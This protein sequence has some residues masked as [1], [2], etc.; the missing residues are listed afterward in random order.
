MVVND[1]QS[2]VALVQILY[3][4]RKRRNPKWPAH[5]KHT[6]GT[7]ERVIATIANAY[8]YRARIQV[9]DFG[10]VTDVK[11]LVIILRETL[12]PHGRECA[13]RPDYADRACK[14]HREGQRVV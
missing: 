12:M 13:T 9:N 11:E 3:E 8:A 1:Y 4:V 10:V 14:E 5:P 6:S 2:N 7:K